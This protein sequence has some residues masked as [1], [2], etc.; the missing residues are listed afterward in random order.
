VNESCDPREHAGIVSDLG[1]SDEDVRRLAVDR[2]SLLPS[3]EGL[4][5]LVAQLGD[6]SW[7]VR[8]A[9]V[10]GI[11][12]VPDSESTAAALIDALADADNPGR[13]NSAV[14]ALVAA[15]RGM[16]PALLDAVRDADADVRKF[17]I[18]ALTG[19]G[20]SEATPGL[21]AALSDPDPN[22]RAAAAEALGTSRGDG[23]PEALL[24]HA[25]D[26]EEDLTVRFS[27]LNALGMIEHPVHS[28]QLAGVLDDA[29]LC[30]PGFE[31]LGRREADTT[32][33]ALMLKGL[34][35][36]SRAHREAAMGGL[37]RSI[38]HCD[39]VEALD[40]V[41]CIR[42][43]VEADGQLMRDA[44]ERLGE[45]DTAIR[46]RLIQFLGL[47]DVEQTVVP[48]LTCAREHAFAQLA[49]ETLVPLG[50]TAERAF[51]A[52]WERLDA[53]A[54]RDACKVL[55]STVG[56]AG[57]QRLLCGLNDVDPEVRLVAAKAMG[58]RGDV[59]GLDPLL[60][61]LE[62][63]AGS[64]LAEMEEEARA[65][66]TAIVA[67]AAQRRGT[68]CVHERVVA[69][70]RLW[71]GRSEDVLRLAVAAV[72]AGIGCAGDAELV[73]LLLKDPS[74]RVR[75]T[76]VDAM[77]RL[78]PAVA[79]EP[80]RLALVD[81]APRVRMAAVRALG[82]IDGDVAVDDLARLVDDD[83]VWVRAAAVRA[84]G[85][86]FA[87]STDAG[88]RELVLEALDSAM[89]DEVLV[90]LGAVEA[91]IEI[92]GDEALRVTALLER[93]EPELVKDAI[94]CLE[95]HAPAAALDLLVPLVEHSEWSV[96]AEATRVLGTRGIARAIPAILRRLQVEQDEFVRETVLRTLERLDA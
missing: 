58:R 63:L 34:Q 1:S 4:P 67:V 27:S 20:D 74:A 90:A 77:V 18:D 3:D 40:V 23:A 53:A 79:T 88:H 25:V 9:V 13:R 54:R 66:V 47:L 41:R 46:L 87:G 42:A 61:R 8:K 17:A 37:L 26:P 57:Y 60:S 68:D 22:V 16:L 85:A 6:P 24:A 44:L 45:G 78:D 51:D 73:T 91:L 30:A 80:L 75:R 19:I 35:S 93:T 7:R 12:A 39:G 31:L 38:A 95:A 50:E 94:S 84:L 49:V 59:A 14:E 10:E 29:T 33:V 48:I 11:V 72:L 71:L 15:G 92:G 2:A 5:L 96:R 86:R 52:A 62:E 82:A 89:C 56:E 69:R 70:L 28:N 83:D 64:D 65:L 55:G 76:A 43:V 32:A 36:S 21:V 81:D